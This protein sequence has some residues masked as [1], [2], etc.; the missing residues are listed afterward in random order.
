MILFSNLDRCTGEEKP[1]RADGEVQ[2]CR[3]AAASLDEF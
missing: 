2:W 3:F 1:F